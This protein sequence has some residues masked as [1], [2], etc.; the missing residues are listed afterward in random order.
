MLHNKCSINYFVVTMLLR[1]RGFM[2]CIPHSALIFY[3]D[4]CL[5]INAFE[6][7]ELTNFFT[8]HKLYSIDRFKLYSINR[9]YYM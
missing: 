3:V 9:L 1:V 2:D 7:Q 8:R 6:Q 4:V 5:A